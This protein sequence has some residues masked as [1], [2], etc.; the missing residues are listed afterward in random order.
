MP[1]DKRIIQKED[2]IPLNIY[3]SERKQFRKKILDF[4]KNRRIPLGPYATFYL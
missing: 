4:K 1:K 3:T 2:I